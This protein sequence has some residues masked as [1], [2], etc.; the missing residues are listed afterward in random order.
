M[1]GP[2]KR[3]KEKFGSSSN[4]RRQ[5]EE[6]VDDSGIQRFQGIEEE[7]IYNK[8][9]MKKNLWVEREII[10]TD[11]P[12]S[13]ME[14]GANHKYITLVRRKWIKFNPTV[15]DNYYGLTAEDI[16]HVPTELD[17]ALV[18]SYLVIRAGS[19]FEFYSANAASYVAHDRPYAY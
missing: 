14:P 18:G 5:M 4:R 11:F 7:N 3:K 15:I 8:W 6:H 1:K 10:L 9:L 17:M 19:S 2:A 13:E 16:E 12:Y